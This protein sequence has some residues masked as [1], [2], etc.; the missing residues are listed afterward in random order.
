MPKVV[1]TEYINELLA[2]AADEARQT[3]IDEEYQEAMHQLNSEYFALMQND[4]DAGYIS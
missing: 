4:R 3:R 2:N 1:K